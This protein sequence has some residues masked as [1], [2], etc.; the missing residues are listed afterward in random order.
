MKKYEETQISKLKIMGL[1]T[2]PPDVPK[3]GL[4]QPEESKERAWCGQESKKQEAACAGLG[5]MDGKRNIFDQRPCI[6]DAP[7]KD[8]HLKHGT[9]F[10]RSHQSHHIHSPEFG[11]RQNDPC[12]SLCS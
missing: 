6:C 9:H 11:K 1:Q 2:Q 4:P 5:V 3:G 7:Q 12:V 10:L 8:M